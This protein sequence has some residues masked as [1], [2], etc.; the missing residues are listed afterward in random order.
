MELIAAGKAPRIVQPEEGAS[1]E[2][3]ITQKPELAVIDWSKNQ[4]QL[5][6]WIRGNDKVSLPRVEPHVRRPAHGPS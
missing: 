1:Y 5:H 6:N 3:A 4:W 2:P